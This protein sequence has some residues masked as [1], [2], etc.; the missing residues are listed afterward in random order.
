MTLPFLACFS[1]N[2]HVSA[3]IVVFFDFVIL[4]IFTMDFA[5]LDTTKKRQ[6]VDSSEDEQFDGEDNQEDVNWPGIEDDGE[7]VP[8]D[9]QTNGPTSH[10][11]DNINRLSKYK[12]KQH[13]NEI[14]KLKT[15]DKRERRKRAEV[16]VVFNLVKSF[17]KYFIFLPRHWVF[18]S[19]RR[20][21][22]SRCECPTTILSSLVMRKCSRTKH[23]M[24]CL[25]ISANKPHRKC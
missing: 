17:L 7:E 21:R 24:R 14:R 25:N 16:S 23:S 20:R 2:K 1:H 19:K 6:E 12:P 9:G 4:F 3:Y 15:K 10:L 8:E 18:Q 11:L 22:L 5:G 13:R